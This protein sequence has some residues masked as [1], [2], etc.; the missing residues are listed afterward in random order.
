MV[1]VVDARPSL[2]HHSTAAFHRRRAGQAVL[3]R[4]FTATRHC[5]HRHL[6][7]Q[8]AASSPRARTGVGVATAI[9]PRDALLA[10]YMLRPHV[11]AAVHHKSTFYLNS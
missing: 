3:S 10:R 7:P 1:I 2:Y 4:P 5:P 11:C 8:H 6:R 9:L